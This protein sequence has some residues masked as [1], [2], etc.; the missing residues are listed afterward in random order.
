M[1]DGKTDHLPRYG[2]PIDVDAISYPVPERPTS[3]LPVFHVDELLLNR[4][5][6]RLRDE[7]KFLNVEQLEQLRAMSLG[8]IWRHRQSWDRDKLIDELEGVLQEFIEEVASFEQD[9]DSD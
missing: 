9:V 8:C 4:L 6:T 2:T 1:V 7:T 5:R 3:P